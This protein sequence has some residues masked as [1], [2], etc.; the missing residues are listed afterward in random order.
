[1][2]DSSSDFAFWATSLQIHV[3]NPHIPVHGSANMSHRAE[4]PHVLSTFLI[5]KCGIPMGAAWLGNASYI[6]L[7]HGENKHWIPRPA[8]VSRHGC[9]ATK[10]SDCRIY[11]VFLQKMAS[12]NNRPQKCRIP[13]RILRFWH[14]LVT[15]T[16]EFHTFRSVARQKCRIPCVILQ[17]TGCDV[18]LLMCFRHSWTENV[19]FLEWFCLLGDLI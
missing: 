4:F 7:P 16:W 15:I 5:R 8:L 6:I 13:R 19:G 18:N 1:M 2:S 10:M 9:W 17:I 12:P 3:R 11:L 14:W